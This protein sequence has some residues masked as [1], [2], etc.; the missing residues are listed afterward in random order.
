[1]KYQKTMSFVFAVAAFAA[2]AESQVDSLTTI[3]PDWHSA[4]AAG[5]CLIETGFGPCAAAEIFGPASNGHIYQGP[6]EETSR[7]LTRFNIYSEECRGA[8]GQINIDGWCAK[9]DDARNHLAAQGVCLGDTGFHLCAVAASGDLPIFGVW[10]CGGGTMTIDSASY[11]GKPIE[12]I[13]KMGED[14]LVT[15]TDGYRFA[16]FDVTTNSFTWYSPQSGDKFDC[17]RP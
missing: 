15:L 2:Q 4:I 8:V 11:E 10:D 7:L 16:A 9:R 5:E 13:E 14:Y 17:R 1:M 3:T 12:V 6:T